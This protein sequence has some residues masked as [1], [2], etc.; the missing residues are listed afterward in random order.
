MQSCF[1]WMGVGLFFMLMAGDVWAFGAVAVNEYERREIMVTNLP[2]QRLAD[3]M[4]MEQCGRGCRIVG[5]FVNSCGAIA[6]APNGTVSWDEGFFDREEAER[7][8]RH[9]CRRVS[10]GE[11]CRVSVQ[12][13][14]RPHEH[15]HEGYRD[16]H[17]HEGDR[18]GYM[19]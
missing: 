17:I 6:W 1:K 9:T 11:H 19:R 5:R 14:G 18:G 8:A 15:R 10:G 13:D 12:C 2:D 3:I 4:A 16:E 7:H